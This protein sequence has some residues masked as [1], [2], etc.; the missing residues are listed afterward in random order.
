MAEFNRRLVQD[1]LID[2]CAERYE[3]VFE[4]AIELRARKR[5]T[6]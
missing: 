4:D 1:Y 6:A 3:R 2:R 5:V